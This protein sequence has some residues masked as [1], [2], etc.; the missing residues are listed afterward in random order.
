MI[1]KE[2]M[3]MQSPYHNIPDVH[4]IRNLLHIISNNLVLDVEQHAHS[5]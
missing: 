1:K 4:P 5:K 3:K 2:N